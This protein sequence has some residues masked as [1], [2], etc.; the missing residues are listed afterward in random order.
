MSI[1]Y[2]ERRIHCKHFNGVINHKCRAGLEYPNGKQLEQ[3]WN[4]QG[5]P[6]PETPCPRAEYPTAEDI[7]RAERESKESFAK[8]KKARAAIVNVTNNK[9]KAGSISCPVCGNTL[10][11]RQFE[12]KHIHAQCCG[13]NCVAWME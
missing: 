1:K 10:Y 13:K 9:P 2:R 3:C 4:Y 12:N 5:K 8:I 6:D 11:F 7:E